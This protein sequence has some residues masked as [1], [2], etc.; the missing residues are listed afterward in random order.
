MKKA[1]KMVWSAAVL[2]PIS[3]YAAGGGAPL[4]L[5]ADFYLF[6]VGQIWMVGVKFF[7]LVRLWPERP[8]GEIFLWTLT[9]NL[10]STLL[11]AF[12][13][14]FLWAAFFGLA[15]SI[16]GISEH[17]ISKILMAAGTWI[18]GDHSVY[19]GLATGI[20]VFLFI[21][22]Y[23]MTVRL[24]YRLLKHYASGRE[25]RRPITLRHVYRMNLFAYAGL[26]ALFFA[27]IGWKFFS[28]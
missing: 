12:L 25:L 1:R 16:P 17:E 5:L 23:F 14:P 6:S 3:A 28:A 2:L 26:V 15:A 21:L 18:D 13:F 27:G 22:I 11:G 19:D 7:C 24:E 9:V 20:S 4:L 10:I 8:R